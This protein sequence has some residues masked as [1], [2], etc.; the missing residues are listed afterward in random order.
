[1]P[2]KVAQVV[3]NLKDLDNSLSDMNLNNS[4]PKNI[5]GS[6]PTC[7]HLS[8]KAYHTPHLGQSATLSATLT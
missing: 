3:W 2:G 6:E 7:S 8:S 5:V 1:M 4:S